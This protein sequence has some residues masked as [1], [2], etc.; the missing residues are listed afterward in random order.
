METSPAMVELHTRFQ[1]FTLQVVKICNLETDGEISPQEAHDRLKALLEKSCFHL[2][3]QFICSALHWNLNHAQL[4][5]KSHYS[6]N[7]DSGSCRGA[8]AE[9]SHALLDI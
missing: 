9:Y 3:I 7:P 5:E 4:S 6:D 8:I 2:D 1:E